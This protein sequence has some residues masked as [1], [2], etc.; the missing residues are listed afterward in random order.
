[1]YSYQDWP[2]KIKNKEIDFFLQQQI[3]LN[4]KVIV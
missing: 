3:S 2:E 1:M 4:Y